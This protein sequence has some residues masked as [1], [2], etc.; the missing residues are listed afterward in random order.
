MYY[1]P[2]MSKAISIVMPE[3]HHR[4]CVWY[5]EQNAAKHLIKYIKGMPLFVVILENA[6]TNMRM[7]KNL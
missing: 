4:L 7:K 5:M 1:N 3:V 6:F 2:A